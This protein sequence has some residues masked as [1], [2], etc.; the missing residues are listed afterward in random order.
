MGA[1]EVADVLDGELGEFGTDK[2]V[3][4]HEAVRA[5]AVTDG[6]ETLGSLGIG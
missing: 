4:L 1:D 5:G 6:D 2:V 3:R